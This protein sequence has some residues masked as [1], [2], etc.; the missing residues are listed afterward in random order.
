MCFNFFEVSYLTTLSVSRLYSVD[1][2]MINECGTVG[3]M[4][5][6]RGN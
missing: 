6:D 1:N 2:R 5:I 4:R 3:G